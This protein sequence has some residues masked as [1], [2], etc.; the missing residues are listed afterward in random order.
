MSLIALSRDTVHPQALREAVTVE[1]VAGSVRL[2][3]PDGS[4]ANV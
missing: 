4:A 3:F 2:G 1:V